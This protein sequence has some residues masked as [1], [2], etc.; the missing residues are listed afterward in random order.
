[1]PPRSDAVSG[2]ASTVAFRKRS[3]SESFPMVGAVRSAAERWLDEPTMSR[4]ALTGYLT[5]LLWSGGRAAP[6]A[7][8]ALRNTVVPG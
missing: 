7:G 4:A 2:A 1:M 6:T 3:G 5:D 8:A